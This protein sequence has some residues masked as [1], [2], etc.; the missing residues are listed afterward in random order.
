MAARV[1][2]RLLAVLDG[3]GVLFAIANDVKKSAPLEVTEDIVEVFVDIAWHEA[4]LTTLTVKNRIYGQPLARAGWC[5]YLE[6][7]PRN[8]EAALSIH[9]ILDG[10]FKEKDLDPESRRI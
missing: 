10:S 9:D 7:T 5:Q 4:G 1:D 2:R 6:S 3:R 8:N